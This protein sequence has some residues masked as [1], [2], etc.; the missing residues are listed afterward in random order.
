MTR[1][2]EGEGLKVNTKLMSDLPMIDCTQIEKN[3]GQLSRLMEIFGGA[4]IGALLS[5]SASTYERQ[6]WG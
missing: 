1:R 3:L 4:T 2:N 5:E 6:H